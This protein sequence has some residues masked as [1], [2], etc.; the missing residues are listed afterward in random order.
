[1][2][3]VVFKKQRGNVQTLKKF[4]QEWNETFEWAWNTAEEQL[5]EEQDDDDDEE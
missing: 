3:A 5:Y 4:F 1:M 2:F